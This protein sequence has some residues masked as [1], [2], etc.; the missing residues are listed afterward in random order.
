[1]DGECVTRS[2]GCC[3]NSPF[4]NLYIS[5]DHLSYQIVFHD[6]CTEYLEILRFILR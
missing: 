2:G 1:M 6:L 4:G 3:E 5:K